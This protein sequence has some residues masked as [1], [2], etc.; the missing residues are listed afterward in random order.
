MTNLELER[1]E[2]YRTLAEGKAGYNEAL[3]LSKDGKR[4]IITEEFSEDGQRTINTTAVYEI[5]KLRPLY[6]K[7]GMLNREL[8]P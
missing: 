4:Y 7:G 5:V 2:Q 3:V 6:F 8:S 1:K